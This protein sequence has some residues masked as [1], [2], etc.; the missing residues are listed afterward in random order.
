MSRKRRRV[1]SLVSIVAIAAAVTAGMAG[2]AAASPSALK[3]LVAYTDDGAPTQLLFDIRAQAGVAGADLFDLTAGTPTA[4]QLSSYDEVVDS[5]D[6]NGFDD[7]TA[8][9]DRLAD[10]VDAGGVVVQFSYGD[11]YPNYTFFT[12]L[13]RWVSGNYSPLTNGNSTNTAGRSL[14]DHDSGNPLLAGVSSLV[15]DLNTDTTVESGATLV[16]KWDDGGNLVAYKG[17]VV[18]VG[19]HVGNESGEDWSGDFGRLAVNAV[20]WLGRHTLAVTKAGTGAGTV[21]S[22]PAGIDCGATCSFDY[23]YV[24]SVV[25]TATPAAGSTFAGWTGDCSGAATCNVNLD[26]A[27]NVTATFTALPP[28]AGPARASFLSSSIT[29]DLKTGK[30]SAKVRCDNLPSDVCVLALDLKAKTKAKSSKSTASKTKLSKIGTAK[31]TIPGATT[32]KVKFKLSKK[33]LRLLKKAKHRKLSVQGVGT[34]KNRA[35]TPT[36]V[37]KKFKLKGKK[38]KK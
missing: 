19:A 29:I 10:Y 17:R 14:G 23:P 15:S 13:G 16:A 36:P 34:S 30:G 25:L 12:P 8:Y 28:T 32:G 4:A 37:S 31:G 5:T 3:I 33:G 27:T 21:T 1:V 20:R 26:K 2:N 11:E 24:T 9:G 22:A 18:G 7:Q 38:K 35:G 6:S